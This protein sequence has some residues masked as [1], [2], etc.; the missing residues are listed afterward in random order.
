MF[1][2]ITL[3]QILHQVD[4]VERKW[5]QVHNLQLMYGHTVRHPTPLPLTLPPPSPLP[6]PHPYPHPYHTPKLLNS[7]PL[8]PIPSPL[9]PEPELQRRYPEII[10]LM[11]G[12]RPYPENDHTDQKPLTFKPQALNLTPET[13][14]QVTLLFLL[15]YSPA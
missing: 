1:F 8:H 11:Y 5:V 3:I 6:L 14:K 9:T 7:E 12:H 15:Y 2:F 10:N 4:H 13:Q